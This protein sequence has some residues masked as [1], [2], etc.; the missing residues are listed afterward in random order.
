M[1]YTFTMDDR[2]HEQ[3]QNKTPQHIVI[4]DFLN[5]ERASRIEEALVDIKPNEKWYQ[6]D[7]LFEKKLATDQIALMPE[8]IKQ[9]LYELN[10]QEFINYLEKLTGIDGLIPDPGLRGGGI[11]AIPTNGFLDI[12]ADRS[13]HPK[14]KLYRRVNVLIYFN[15]NYSSIY[16]GQLELWN[17]E[18]TECK[19]S[20][21]PTYNRAVIFNTDATSFH[22]HP[23]PWLSMKPRL[24]IATYYFTSTIPEDFKANL[25]STDF[26]A[27]PQDPI[28]ITKDAL[29]A[30]RRKLRL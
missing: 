8:A 7:S 12:H 14:L 11:H 26:R 23:M 25:E 21:E 2:F 24:S 4:D 19:Y 20:I 10:G 15:R 22:G 27:R 1:A 17:Q 13:F 18:M 16:Q 28:D 3:Y 5:H 9:I 29:R 6:Y 30:E